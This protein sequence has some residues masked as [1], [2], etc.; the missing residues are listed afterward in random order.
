MNCSEKLCTATTQTTHNS[1][2]RNILRS[3]QLHT[4][5][6]NRHLNVEIILFSHFNYPFT[7]NSGSGK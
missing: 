6:S 5:F 4:F 3:F 7:N 2:L 1:S